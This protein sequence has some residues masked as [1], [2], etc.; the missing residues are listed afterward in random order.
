MD[1]RE[2]I[3]ESARLLSVRAPRLALGTPVGYER[4]YIHPYRREVNI[5]GSRSPERFHRDIP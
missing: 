4:T 5:V 3:T 1:I 2:E